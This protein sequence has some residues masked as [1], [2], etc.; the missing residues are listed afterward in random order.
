M[1]PLVDAVPSTCM[2]SNA[3]TPSPRYMPSCPEIQAAQGPGN[4]DV[5]CARGSIAAAWPCDVLWST[6]CSA[7]CRPCA[8]RRCVDSLASR[9]ECAGVVCCDMVQ[10]SFGCAAYFVDFDPNLGIFS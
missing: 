10:M 6:R 5:M 2:D 3:K 7:V 4:G 8:E 1:R 9:V